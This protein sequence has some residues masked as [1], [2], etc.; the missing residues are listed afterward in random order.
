MLAFASLTVIVPVGFY[1]K[2]YDGP[3]SDWVNNSLGGVFYVIFWCLLLFFLFPGARTWTIALGVLL[4]TCVLEFAQ[5]WHPPALTL[6]RSHFL[7][8]TLLGNTFSWIDFPYYL[9][10][11][12]VGWA[13]IS[14]L[15]HK[16][17]P[18][19]NTVP[20]NMR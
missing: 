11:A 17:A 12:A 3:A 13:W 9:G 14:Q 16:F 1:T 5:L 15:Q 19:I 20:R 10:G 6:I 4:V 8:A 7:G 2:F 18:Q